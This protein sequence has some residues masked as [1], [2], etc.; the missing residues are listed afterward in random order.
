MQCNLFLQLV[1][2]QFHLILEVMI[3]SCEA[4]T[5]KTGLN[6]LCI[7]SHKYKANSS[8]HLHLFECPDILLSQYM[9]ILLRGIVLQTAGWSLYTNNLKATYKQV[10]CNAANR[11]H[12]SIQN[13]LNKQTVK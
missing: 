4:S 12:M 9:H 6:F 2:N 13:I 10:A 8:S 1:L 11:I 3:K 5:S 7:S